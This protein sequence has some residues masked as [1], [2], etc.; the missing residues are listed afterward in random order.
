MTTSTQKRVNEQPDLASTDEASIPDVLLAWDNVFKGLKV[1]FKSHTKV[2]LSDFH[3]SVKAIIV[4][5]ISM[6]A[7]VCIGI[8]VW[9]TLLVG[10]V[11]GLMTLGISWVW[12]MITVLGLNCIALMVVKRIYNSAITSI[13]MKTSADLIFS[14]D[15]HSDNK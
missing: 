13:G 14:S 12:C 10:L 2:V 5:L 3:L 1:K 6:M 7:L 8:I 4:M 15:H 11:Y 9:V